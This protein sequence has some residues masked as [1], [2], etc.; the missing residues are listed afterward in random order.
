MQEL[1]D[2]GGRIR[3]LRQA[4]ELTQEELAERSEL[5][6][7]FI[8]QVERGKTSISIDSLLMILNALNVHISDFFRKQKEQIVF[9][10]S[11]AQSLEREGVESFRTLVPG[12]ANRTMEPVHVR[13]EHGQKVDMSP[14]GGEQYGYVL[15]GELRLSIGSQRFRARSGDSFYADG[16]HSLTL[17]NK[18][19]RP[20]EFL[21]ITS[22]P[23]F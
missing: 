3:T 15:R 8:S 23:Y 5:T 11:E 7:G 1:N 18:G 17:E 20:V 12:A 22:P 13:L 14:F 16:T 4:A 19:K 6:A 21:W 10:G 9:R 2:I